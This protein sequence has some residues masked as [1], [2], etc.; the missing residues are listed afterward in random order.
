[1][2]IYFSKII[3]LFISPIIY[4]LFSAGL[5]YRK[6]CLKLQNSENDRN[7]LLSTSATP[8]LNL[9]ISLPYVYNTTI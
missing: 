8:P 3:L 7:D 2:W 4:C 6:G 9:D 5:S 1:M